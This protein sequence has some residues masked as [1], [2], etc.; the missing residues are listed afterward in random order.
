MP[1]Y[2]FEC[3]A[4]HLTTVVCRIDDR[5]R[6]VECHKCGGATTRVYSLA[7]VHT[8]EEYADVDLADE[9]DGTPFVVTSKNQ[10]ARRMRELNLEQVPL[11]ERARDRSMKGTIFSIP[12]GR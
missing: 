9:H 12:R 4:G 1:S 3:E 5:E 11:S 8:L 6:P 7:T 10:K 2:E